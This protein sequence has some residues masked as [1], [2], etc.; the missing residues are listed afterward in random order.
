[1]AKRCLRYGSGGK[2]RC[3]LDPGAR[4]RESRPRKWVAAKPTDQQTSGPER[5]SSARRGR[6]VRAVLKKRHR[7][8]L[9]ALACAV[10]MG[11]PEASVQAA[12]PSH[13][14]VTWSGLEPDK[15]A[16]AWYIKRYV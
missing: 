14:Y 4:H 6:C 1:M 12:D 8:S 13:L 11:I 10:V 2:S 15:A 9:A 16:S 7:R 3:A 5:P